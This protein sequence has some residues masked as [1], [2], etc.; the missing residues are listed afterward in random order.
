M[1]AT[2]TPSTIAQGG[3]LYGKLSSWD[4]Y[5]PVSTAALVLTLASTVLAAFPSP[6]PG[7]SD[8]PAKVA[9]LMR[10][11]LWMMNSPPRTRETEA[12]IAPS[13]STETPKKKA[14][15]RRGR[16]PAAQKLSQSPTSL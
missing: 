2:T 8:D 6:L 4:A 14:P 13:L 3:R 11:A 15:Q 1:A 9:S 5:A 16:K 7:F 10:W 12:T